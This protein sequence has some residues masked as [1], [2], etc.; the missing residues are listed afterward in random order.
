VKSAL[1][2]ESCALPAAC[3]LTMLPQLG[4]LIGPDA[5]KRSVLFERRS[6][7]ALGEIGRSSL[8]PAQID[9]ES[10]NTCNYLSANSE[11]RFTI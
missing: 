9:L 4:A 7:G 5:P 11:S 10:S 6:I 8:L 2:L 1:R 3:D